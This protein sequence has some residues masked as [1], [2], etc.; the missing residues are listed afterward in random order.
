[1]RDD[2][3][4][5][6]DSDAAVATPSLR[7]LGS[8]A[9][10]VVA[11]AAAANDVRL[12]TGQSR[13]PSCPKRAAA[14]ARRAPLPTV[15]PLPTERAKRA[16]AADSEVQSLAVGAVGR[17][18]WLPRTEQWCAS[19]IPRR[20]LPSWCNQVPGH[21]STSVALQKEWGGFEAVILDRTTAGYCP[22]FSHSGFHRRNS[23]GAL[24]GSPTECP[25]RLLHVYTDSTCTRQV[26]VVAT[27]SELVP[28]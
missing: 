17:R 21:R 16:S 14:D 27:I 18:V 7:V 13:T 24:V 23:G 6:A 20:G 8:V 5:A 28:L 9:C 4:A 11:E 22:S 10:E 1:M 25:C 3:F 26:E 19:G 12:L 15:P 2:F